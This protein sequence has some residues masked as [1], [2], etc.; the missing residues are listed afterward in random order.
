MHVRPHDFFQGRGKFMDAQNALSSKKLTSFFK[1]PL[2][3]PCLPAPMAISVLKSSMHSKLNLWT[4][5]TWPKV[6]DWNWETITDIIGLYSTTVTYLADKAIEFGEKRKIKALTPKGFY[7]VQGHSRSF[8]VIEVCTNR[9]PLYDS[10]LVINS[11]WQCI[12]YRCGAI[13][14]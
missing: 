5:I 4:L 9:K 10:L 14:A 1:C 8:K 6:E 7:D 3:P 11:N 12:S 13:A 2:A